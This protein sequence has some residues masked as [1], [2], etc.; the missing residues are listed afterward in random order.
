VANGSFPREHDPETVPVKRMELLVTPDNAAERVVSVIDGATESVD[1]VQM[2]V[3]GPDG[4]FLRAV[5]RAARRG[6]DVRVLLSSAWYVREENRRLVEQLRER[7]D[8]E[9]LP[10]QARLADP[11]G[12]FEK[13]HAKGMVVDGDQALVGSLN[14]NGESVRENREGLVLLEGTEVGA[15]YQAVFEADWGAGGSSLPGG[16]L[17]LGSLA[18]VGGAVVLAVLVLRRVEF[19]ENVGV[20]PR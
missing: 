11:G 10:I 14:W 18:A 5:V 12:R 19:G 2:T 9:A 20:G 6:V 15:Y 1:V 3:D 16:S 13:V 4:R 17:P 7:A 8:D